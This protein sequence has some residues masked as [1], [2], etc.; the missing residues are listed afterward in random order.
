MQDRYVGDV[1]DFVK[2]GL[3]RALNDAGLSVGLAWY[4]V[5]DESHNDDGRHVSYLKNS[6]FRQ[7]DHDLHDTMKRIVDTENRRVE[8][9]E[10][11]RIL[12]KGTKFHNTPL[13]FDD[14]PR[15][16]SKN[17][18]LLRQKRKNVWMKEV[19]DTIEGCDIV[20]F[21]P[22][23]GLEVKSVKPLTKKAPKYLFWSDLEPFVEKQQSLV[24]YN[25]ASRQGTV[26]NQ[27]K[28]RTKEISDR[29]P[30][31]KNAVSLLSRRYSIRCFYVIPANR[32]KAAC[33]SA[34]NNLVNGHWGDNNLFELA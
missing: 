33:E 25:H 13:S 7:C 16:P 17:G 30:Y 19:T 31:G 32:H 9:V 8:A 24:I 12:G 11:S 6:L 5:P 2:Y 10:Q 28:R 21:D 20:F 26:S 18:R 15:L 27:V 34:V 22:D 1:G 4:R 23:N 14:L 29:I 3:I